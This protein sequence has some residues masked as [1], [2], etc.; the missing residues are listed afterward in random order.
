MTTTALIA[1]RAHYYS[2]ACLH[3]K[4]D[5]CPGQC[6]FCTRSCMCS[7]HTAEPTPAGEPTEDKAMSDMYDPEAEPVEETTGDVAEE[8]DEEIPDEESDVAPE[9]LGERFEGQGQEPPSR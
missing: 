8:N 5:R 6:E 9:S 2:T 4:H 3:T 1:E 7:C